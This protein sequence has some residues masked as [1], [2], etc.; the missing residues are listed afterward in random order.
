MLFRRDIEPRC[1]YCAKGSAIN[2][3]EVICPR[4]GVVAAGFHCSGF[5]Y[6]P[7]K[8]VPPRPVKLETSQLSEKDFQI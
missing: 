6:D 8:R 5:R 2:D 7:L 3:R 4:K 1:V